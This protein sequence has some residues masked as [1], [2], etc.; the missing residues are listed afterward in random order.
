MTAAPQASK[1]SGPDCGT[2]HAEVPSQVDPSAKGQFHEIH[3]NDVFLVS[4]ALIFAID[5][6]DQDFA[7]GLQSKLSNLSLAH[8]DDDESEPF[9]CDV[10]VTQERSGFKARRRGKLFSCSKKRKEAPWTTIGAVPFSPKL[11]TSYQ[12]PQLRT[13]AIRTLDLV[14]AA[15]AHP[16]AAVHCKLRE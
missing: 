9:H 5:R 1:R 10:D 15:D 6:M 4:S 16:D 8:S 13:N 11:F 2:A 14:P 3:L 7:A 12:Y